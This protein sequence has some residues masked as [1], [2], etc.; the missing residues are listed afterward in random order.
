[1]NIQNDNQ[2][3]PFGAQK[4]SLTLH[5][6][7][8]EAHL[9]ETG[10]ND[11]DEGDDWNG[12]EVDSESSDS[13]SEEGW[14][15]V[16][17]DSDEDLVVSD[18][19]DGEGGPKNDEPSAA[20]ERTDGYGIASE[21]ILTP[22]DFA[23]MKDLQSR[24]DDQQNGSGT[25]RK[26]AVTRSSNQAGQ[27]DKALDEGDIVG[28]RKKAKATYEERMESIKQGR[29]GR[30][31]FGSMKGK[32]AK[33]SS[34]SSTNREKARNKPIMMVMASGAVKS[35]KRASLK[36]KQRRLKAHNDKQKKRKS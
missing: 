2:P 27:S 10:E 26:F 18:S 20:P 8:L 4:R 11:A 34:S 23:L 35:K 3:L 29:E 15:D 36:D 31:K 25:K 32:K 12:W 7:L 13:S 5:R 6:K 9:R 28:P 17:S 14:I 22:A 16:P 19:E 33:E 24:T 1:M 30:A 21:K